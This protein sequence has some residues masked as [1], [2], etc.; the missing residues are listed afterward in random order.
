MQVCYLNCVRILCKFGAN[1]NCYSRSHLTPLHVLVFT[2]S[3]NISLAR[4]REKDEGFEFIRNLLTLLLQVRG[5][6]PFPRNLG[7]FNNFFFLFPF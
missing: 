3:E 1:P 2:A 5:K 6:R 7:C 4:E